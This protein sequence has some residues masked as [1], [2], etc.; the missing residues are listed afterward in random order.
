MPE[1]ISAEWSSDV[2]QVRIIIGQQ[3]LIGAVV[4]GD[5]TISRPLQELITQQVD[6]SAIHHPLL[7]PKAPIARIIIDFWT[8]Y[9]RENDRSPK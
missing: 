8:Q 4:L 5:Q 1:A 2:N 3:T 7:Q 9:S 6:I